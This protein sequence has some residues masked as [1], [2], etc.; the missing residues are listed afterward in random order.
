MIVEIDNQGEALSL[1]PYW[2]SEIV[3]AG[4]R[5][6][7]RLSEAFTPTYAGPQP[8]WVAI[9]SWTMPDTSALFIS[10]EG[11]TLVTIIADM[12]VTA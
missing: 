3:V 11:M 8:A 10:K 9:P 4:I 2:Q 5:T 1:R 12:A 7:L 6:Y